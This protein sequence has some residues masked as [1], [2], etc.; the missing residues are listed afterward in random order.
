MTR[1]PLFDIPHYLRVFQTYLGARMYLIFGLA[2]F[3]VVAEG[4]GILMLLPL[5][6]GL[7]AGGAEPTGVAAFVQSMLSAVGLGESTTWLLV[8]ITAAFIAK[9]ALLFLANGYRAYL[10]GLLLRELRGRLFDRYSH[11]RYRHYVSQSTGHFTNVINQQIRL[12]FTLL[13][14]RHTRHKCIHIQPI[15]HSAVKNHHSQI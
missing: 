10:Q 11:M 9:G 3:A 12:I 4:V 13:G 1:N 8:L 6:G 14:F 15:G 2:L 7:D 5:L